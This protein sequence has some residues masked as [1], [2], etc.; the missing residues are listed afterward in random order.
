MLYSVVKDPF[1]TV[2]NLNHDLDVIRQ[3]A[4]LWK[5]EFNPDSTKQANEVL[6]SYKKTPPNHPHLFFNGTQVTQ[7][8]Y[9]LINI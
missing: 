9:P 6:F 8:I 3:W 1:Q 5:M 4:Y 2:D 7:M